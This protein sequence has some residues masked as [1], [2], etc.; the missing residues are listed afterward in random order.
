MGKKVSRPSKK[1]SSP[2]EASDIDIMATITAE[3]DLGDEDIE[4][5][6]NDP[7]LLGELL[8]LTQP[9]DGVVL[10]DNNEEE[11]SESEPESNS[12]KEEPDILTTLK[13][14]L[15][16]YKTAEAKAKENNESSRARRFGRGIKT[17]EDL[18]KKAKAGKT[19]SPSDIPTVIAL[20]LKPAPPVQPDVQNEG[21]GE[22]ENNA[23]GENLNEN[24]SKENS[25]DSPPDTM[26]L[27]LE[28]LKMYQTAEAKAK[29]GGETSRARRFNRGIKT[30]EGLI[31][32]A[33]TGQDIPESDIPPAVAL[34]LK[35]APPP[36][37][38]SADVEVVDSEDADTEMNADAL[39]NNNTNDEESG[40]NEGNIL[41][42][43][44]ERLKMY[45][46]AESKAK[47]EGESSR[48][49]R[50]NRGIKTLQDL[51]KKA[52]G[53]VSI[54]QDDIPPP[55][56]LNLKPVPPPVATMEEEDEPQSV[57]LKNENLVQSSDNTPLSPVK[58]TLGD[59]DDE[60][61]DLDN[62]ELWEETPKTVMEGLEQRIR[63]YT[64]LLNK[65]KEIGDEESVSNN[66]KIIQI[67]LN[68]V[69]TYK[70]GGYVDVLKLPTPKG[71]PPIPIPF[72]IS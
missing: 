70:N 51:I 17:L 48:A 11:D 32:L 10:D 41:E 33:K 68:A 25:N 31:K 29:E 6:E 3:I 53:G 55:I 35:P 37:P 66:E 34:N 49:R 63:I 4:V 44:T 28:R 24:I 22:P 16:M 52:S 43:L 45:Q 42:I 18:I 12:T 67:Y 13:D 50:F 39:D 14:R 69:T 7:D 19:I 2:D 8:E 1:A 27:L 60:D 5:D 47:Q 72:H 40:E 20:N 46:T 38:P 71:C 61:I 26:S 9:D 59:D 58:F 15:K 56:A 64:K 30:I 23:N 36:P 62:E 57:P 21:E 54:A 65:A